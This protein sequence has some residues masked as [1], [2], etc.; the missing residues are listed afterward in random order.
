MK[1][2]LFFI[3]IFIGFTSESF[4]QSDFSSKF[5]A[6]APINKSPKIKKEIPPKTTIPAEI[7]IPPIKTPN[8]FKN[9]E[10]FNPNPKPSS[11]LTMPSKI[12][13][14]PK[15]DFINP[16]DAYAD[17]MTKDMDKTLVKEGLKEDKSL[18]DYK[19]RYLG[20]Y[21][22]KSDFFIVKYRDYIAIDGDL[23]NVYLNG[24]ILRSELYLGSNF[25][26]L[27]IPLALGF[28]V[29]ELV[30]VSTGTSGGNTAEIHFIDDVNK[31]VTSEYWD[32]LALGVRIKTTVIREK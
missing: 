4:S 30:V 31:S 14:T 19:D 13:M 27:K 23:I 9:P 22:T 24:K 17:K 29:I 11:Q 5:K 21:K 8:V 1:Q 32:N 6:I 16:G 15:N 7:D 26:E 12:S 25:G 3:I 18:L 20:E 28:N 2:I 10:V